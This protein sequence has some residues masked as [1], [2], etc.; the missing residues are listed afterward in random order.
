MKYNILQDAAKLYSGEKKEFKAKNGKVYEF[1]IQQRFSEDRKER[2]TR[3]A[4][5]L[6]RALSN[7][8]IITDRSVVTAVLLVKHFTDI[9]I[10][11]DFP[12]YYSLTMPIIKQYEI[13]VQ[14]CDA[15]ND[16]GIWGDILNSFNKDE[17][18]ALPEWIA[19]YT[20]NVQE[21]TDKLKETTKKEAKKNKSKPK[22]K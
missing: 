19:N 10:K 14:I 20:K 7:G 3:N 8:D 18:N 22:K 2:F 6:E 4:L 17:I 5:S 16:L 13:D 15:L 21:L 11:D 12:H 9:I 1:E